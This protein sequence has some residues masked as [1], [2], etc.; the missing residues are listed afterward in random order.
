MFNCTYFYDSYM[1]VG[2]ITCSS[3]SVSIASVSSPLLYMCVLGSVASLYWVF[4]RVVSYRRSR[5]I[6]P[7]DDESFPLIGI[8]T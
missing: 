6:L 8:G 1:E 4:S 7:V 5:H 3:P 2:R